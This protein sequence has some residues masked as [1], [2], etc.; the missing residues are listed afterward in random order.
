MGGVRDEGVERFEVRR[1]PWGRR[2]SLKCR[3]WGAPG[4][5]RRCCRK[6]AMV[7]GGAVVVARG[8]MTSWRERPSCLDR[9]RV[10]A[11][12]RGLRLQET[13]RNGSL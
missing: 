4:G 8:G 13:T 7:G 12:R 3:R 10:R 1:S 2:G 5:G 6:G 9:E 11:W